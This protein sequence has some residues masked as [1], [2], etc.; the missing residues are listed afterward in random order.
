MIFFINSN[1]YASVL[2]CN[3]TLFYT[4][5]K[6]I[7]KEKTNSTNKQENFLYLS[8]KDS[9]NCFYPLRIAAVVA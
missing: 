6:S 2:V 8:Y 1:K 3:L 5:Q 7:I 9:S 4:V